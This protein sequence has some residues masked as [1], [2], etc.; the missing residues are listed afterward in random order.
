MHP[1]NWRNARPRLIVLILALLTASPL[2]AQSV[3]VTASLAVTHG[4]AHP[5]SYVP[6]KLKATNNSRDTVTELR[7]SSGSPVDVVAPW[8]LPPGESG[9]KT[10]PA[11]YLGGELRL[12]MEFR[13]AAS[14]V[15]AQ[16]APDSLSPRVAPQ[17][18]EPAL[19]PFPAGADEVVQPDAYRLLSLRPWPAEERLHLWL[20]LAVFTLAA[21]VVGVVLPRRRAIA[22]AAAL[23]AL[24]AAATALIWTFGELREARIEE[25]RVFYVGGGRPQAALEHF[26]VLASRGGEV[27]RFALGKGG[28]LPLPLP[29]LASSEELF[30]PLATLHLGDEAWVETRRPQAIFHILD[31]AQPPLDL[32]IE[33]GAQPDLAAIAKRADVVAALY[34]DGDRAADAA[35]KSQALGAWSVEWKSSAD[36]DLAY[37]GRSLAWWDRA[38]REGNGPALL[39]WCR[40]PLPPGEKPSENRTRL[41]AVAICTPE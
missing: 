23:V 1:R 21:L 10:V 8:Q 35:G 41:P 28:Q 7:L 27:A 30:Q 11:F 25:A 38:R 15:I 40:D 36:P 20:W 22:A 12:A 4:Y 16:A 5:G 13:N 18:A 3:D 2:Y 6:V 26:A 39:V 37:A 14:K 17:G 19:T 9:E 33:K 31:R 24:A 32:K 34:V 29:L